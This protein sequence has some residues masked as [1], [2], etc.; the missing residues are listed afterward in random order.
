MEIIVRVRYGSLKQ[1]IERFGERR[2]LL[3]IKSKEEESSLNEIVTMLSRHFGILPK[4]F[5]LKRDN[6]K[7]KVFVI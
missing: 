5:Q 1:S 7:D 3:F 6:G 2:Y 4:D